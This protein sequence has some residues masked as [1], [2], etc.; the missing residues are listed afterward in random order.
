M[1]N[2]NQAPLPRLSKRRWYVL[3]L[4]SGAISSTWLYLYYNLNQPPFNWWID[5]MEIPQRDV[6][7]ERKLTKLTWFFSDTVVIIWPF[8]CRVYVCVGLTRVHSTCQT[9]TQSTICSWRPPSPTDWNSGTY[10]QTGFFSWSRF[11]VV[12]DNNMIL[13]KM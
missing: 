9:L 1:T 7:A 3:R 8:M 4:L 12:N 2:A 5:W 10:D 11:R 6:S 13:T